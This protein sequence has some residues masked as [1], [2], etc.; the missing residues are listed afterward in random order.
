MSRF[1]EGFP[2]FWNWSGGL[3]TSWDKLNFGLMYHDYGRR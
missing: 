1:S 2:D 3:G